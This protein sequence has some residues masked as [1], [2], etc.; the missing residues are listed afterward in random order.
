MSRRTLALLLFNL[1]RKTQT[2]QD[3]SSSR[4]RGTSNVH[5]Q[6]RNVLLWRLAQAANVAAPQLVTHSTCPG[7]TSSKKINPTRM[8]EGVP[9]HF[10]NGT[11][12][13]LVERQ[14]RSLPQPA[15][16]AARHEPISGVFFSSRFA[17]QEQAGAHNGSKSPT[18]VVRVARG[19]LHGSLWP[20]AVPFP[21][22]WPY[23][24]P[25]RLRRWE[26]FPAQRATVLG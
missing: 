16:E 4:S 21:K 10:G 19:E 11:F 24:I 13:C 25:S 23:C 9:G 5:V 6:Q 18:M 15:P 14:S 17:C 8:D 1:L 26:P 22:T 2:R 20:K 12:L 7:R 3:P